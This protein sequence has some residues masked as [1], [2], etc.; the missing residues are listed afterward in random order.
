MVHGVVMCGLCLLCS[1]NICGNDG[2]CWFMVVVKYIVVS[3][4]FMVAYSYSN[5]GIVSYV[6]NYWIEYFGRGFSG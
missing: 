4:S 2:W 5:I 3:V 6:G 1:N